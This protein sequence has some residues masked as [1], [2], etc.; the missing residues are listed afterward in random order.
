MTLKELGNRVRIVSTLLLVM[1]GCALAITVF[2]LVTN[3]VV[4]FSISLICFVAGFAYV[5][6]YLHDLLRIND[7]NVSRLMLELSLL[8]GWMD[9]RK[10]DL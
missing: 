1:F 9:I 3:E 4:L 6:R 2:C 10:S 8:Y 5:F 7:E